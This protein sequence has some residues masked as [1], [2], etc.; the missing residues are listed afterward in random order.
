MRVYKSRM[1]QRYHVQ[2]RWLRLNGGIPDSA[3]W[4]DP[5]NEADECAILSWDYHDSE[6]YG[7]INLTRMSEFHKVKI[8][9]NLSAWDIP[10]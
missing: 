1:R 7:W 6:F 5:Q 3:S 4:F 2:Y 8:K 10:F 9:R